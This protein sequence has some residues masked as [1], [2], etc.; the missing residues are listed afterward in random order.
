MKTY[1]IFSAAGK[2]LRFRGNPIATVKSG[3]IETATTHGSVWFELNAYDRE[4][5]HFV[6]TIAAQYADS[7][8]DEVFD[9][10]STSSVTAADDFL[11]DFDPSIILPRDILSETGAKRTSA[12]VTADHAYYAAA[13]RLIREL[14]DHAVRQQALRENSE[15]ASQPASELDETFLQG[16]IVNRIRALFGI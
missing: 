2:T 13:R 10:Y 1:Q 6:L 5:N 4:P 9:F 14:N 8:I 11:Y 3:P 12:L 15:Q 7:D 16:K